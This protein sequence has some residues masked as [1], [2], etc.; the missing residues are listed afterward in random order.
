M[1]TYQIFVLE[2]SNGLYQLR[3]TGNEFEIRSD[4]EAFLR[5]PTGYFGVKLTIL[6]VYQHS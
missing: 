3:F 2:N 4:A 6:E 5:N 1:I